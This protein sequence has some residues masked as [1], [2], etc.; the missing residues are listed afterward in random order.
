[1]SAINPL[2]IAITEQLDTLIIRLHSGTDCPPADQLRLEGLM[3]AAVLLNLTD[4][5]AL[6]RLFETRYRHL[7]DRCIRAQFG[8]NWTEFF[9]FPSLPLFAK[10]APVQPTTK[11]QS[12]T[13]EP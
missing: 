3:Q 1:M 10:A 5:A 6:Q 2:L 12:F 13:R 7:T 11:A 8:D 4:K 9:H